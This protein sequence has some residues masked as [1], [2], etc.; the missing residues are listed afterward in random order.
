MEKMLAKCVWH[1]LIILSISAFCTAGKNFFEVC[2]RENM[3]RWNGPDVYSGWLPDDVMT[4]SFNYFDSS[5][6]L[7]LRDTYVQAVYI[8]TYVQAVYITTYVQAVYITTYVQAVYI[9]TYVQVVYI[10]HAPSCEDIIIRSH[11]PVVLYI[12]NKQCLQ[13]SLFIYIYVT[14]SL[15]ITYLKSYLIP[16]YL[17]GCVMFR[18]P[19]DSA[20]VIP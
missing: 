11:T 6:V 2:N 8:T 9:T 16:A 4:L 10:T 17:K 7:D 5:A 13:V 3:C 18:H 14:W 1:V 15:Y 12:D 20:L 19:D